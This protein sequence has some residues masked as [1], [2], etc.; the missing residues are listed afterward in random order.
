MEGHWQI[1]LMDEQIWRETVMESR[2]WGY[3]DLSRALIL[4]DA[5]H[6]CTRW[7]ILS[8]RFAPAVTPNS[9]VAFA[10]ISTEGVKTDT[11]NDKNLNWL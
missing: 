6:S 3:K 9:S 4:T 2:I 5:Q 11:K 8:L 10:W 1:K 7:N